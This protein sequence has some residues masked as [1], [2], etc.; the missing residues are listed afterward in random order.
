M[1]D[2]IG[3][4]YQLSK[5]S[6]SKIAGKMGVSRAYITQVLSGKKNLTLKTISD[7]CR[8]CGFELDLK[9]K[10]MKINKNFPSIPDSMKW[11]FWDADFS[12]LDPVTH[13]KYILERILGRG[14]TE[15]V[16]WMRVHYPK[17]QILN[18][19][20]KNLSR[21]DVKSLNYWALI[22]GKEE[23]WT[24]PLPPPRA[25]SWQLLESANP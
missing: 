3:K 7:F 12:R 9:L 14:N 17:R 24:T 21:M 25:A 23:K 18:F 15:A 2:L 8:C 20:N 13:K 4:A 19:I 16:E 5:S 11:L 6:K 22:Y 1:N 10:K